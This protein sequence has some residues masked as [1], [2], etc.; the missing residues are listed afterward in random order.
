LDDPLGPVVVTLAEAVVANLPLGVDEVQRR[1]VVVGEGAPDRVVVVDRDRVV[2][3]QVFDLSA[4]VVEVVLEVELGRVDANHHQ[5][6]ILVPAPGRV[7]PMPSP[8]GIPSGPTG[9]GVTRRA[10]R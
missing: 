2:D 10:G 5:P 3:P 6:V 8:G 4:D 1:P 9:A 7:P